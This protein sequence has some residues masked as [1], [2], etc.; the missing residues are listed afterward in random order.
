MEQTKRIGNVYKAILNTGNRN[1]A[2][3]DGDFSSDQ[4]VYSFPII[5]TVTKAGKENTWQIIVYPYDTTAGKE[6]RFKKEMFVH[7]NVI[8]FENAMKAKYPNVIVDYAKASSDYKE[9]LTEEEAKTYEKLCKTYQ[10][11][12]PQP[13]NIIGKIKVICKTH[14]GTERSNV[15][16]D[17]TEGKHLGKTNAQNTI[18]QAFIEANSHYRKKTSKS[19][20]TIQ[21]PLP[22]LVAK[23]GS[24]KDSTLTEAEYAAG[25]YVERKYDGIRLLS[26]KVDGV[27]NLYSRTGKDFTGLDEVSEDMTKLIGD[28]NIYIDGELYAPNT[29]L[30]DIS[31][32]VRRGSASDI[33]IYIFDC[34]NPDDTQMTQKDRKELLGSLFKAVRHQL[35]HTVLVESTLVYNAKEVDTLFDK[36]LKEGNEGCIIRKIDGP[37]ECSINNYHSNHI[38]K[39][40]PLN[41]AEYRVIGYTQG[42]KGKDVGCVIF[43]LETENCQKFSAVPNMKYKERKK[44]FDE[45]QTHDNL[46]E[47]KYKGKM[48]T[49]EYSVLSTLRV[50]QQ[51]KFICLR[52]YE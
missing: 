46:F 47:N 27:M 14:L 37:Y 44:L 18:T 3:I 6:K 42:N 21:K 48:A 22:M 8:A 40:K 45:F 38:L 41:S 26:R 4:R 30:Q 43:T 15:E 25:V 23:S 20:E 10:A 28:T 36:Y 31:G 1:E 19:S 7:K 33:K 11:P 17:V 52:D 5:K 16:T 32:K 49:V 12:E 9:V 29:K 34:Y 2:S 51:P 13:A 24:S 35:T 39:R 50:P